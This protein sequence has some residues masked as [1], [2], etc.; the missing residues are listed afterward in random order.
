MGLLDSVAGAVLGK[1]LGGNQGGVGQIAMDLLNNSG[2]LGGML[3]K[4]KQ[5]GLA[6]QAASWVG[7]GENLPVSADQITSVLGND[8]I[9]AMAAKFGIS[10]EELSGKIAQY[11]PEMVDKAT[12]DG[13][14]TEKSGDLLSSVLGMFK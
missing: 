11:L 12:P 6:E 1:V 4:F 7:K 8:T 9:T 5:G 2:G 14:V 3:D 10:T 13:A